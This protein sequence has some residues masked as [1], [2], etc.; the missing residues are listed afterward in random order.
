MI[1]ELE[2][3]EEQTEFNEELHVG[4][5][6]STYKFLGDINIQSIVQT[7]TH[8]HAQKHICTRL[9]SSMSSDT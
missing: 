8:T 4:D 9:Y 7:Q 3:S 2:E 5:Y 6:V 1:E